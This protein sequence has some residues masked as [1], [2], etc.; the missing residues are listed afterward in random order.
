MTSKQN[1]WL[2][3]FG[4]TPIPQSIKNKSNR[5]CI[6]ATKAGALLNSNQ[7]SDQRKHGNAGK[8]KKGHRPFSDK[9]ISILRTKILGL[10]DEKIID[11]RIQ[12]ATIEADEEIDGRQYLPR[13]ENDEK[14]SFIT[15][16][17]YSSAIRDYYTN[18]FPSDKEQKVIDLYK[19]G[20]RINKIVADLIVTKFFVK[21]TLIKFGVTNRV[22]WPVKSY[23]Q[24][25]KSLSVQGK[26]AREIM[27]VVDCDSSTVYRVLNE[28]KK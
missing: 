6:A 27:K 11:R 17:N 14:M 25:I 24:T 1:S 18:P 2:V 15:F 20:N 4:V 5:S 3:S 22:K 8:T 19:A 28:G 9:E 23:K 26:T 13:N 7:L 10:V 16:R 21:F 12:Y